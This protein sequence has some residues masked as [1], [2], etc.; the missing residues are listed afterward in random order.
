MVIDELC[1]TDERPEDNT[2]HP[3]HYSNRAIEP[4]EFI[5]KNH[6]GFCEGSIIKYAARHK[7][8]GGAKDIR[9]IIKYAQLILHYQYGEP[10]NE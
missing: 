6:L 3:I 10:L 7:E 9:K 5:E 4:I 8:K 1:M 2:P